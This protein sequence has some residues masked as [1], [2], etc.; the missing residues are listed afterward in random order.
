[1]RWSVVLAAPCLC[2]QDAL[3]PRQ[4]YQYAITRAA[5]PLPAARLARLGGSFAA[6]APPQAATSEKVR[7]R[8]SVPCGGGPRSLL[9]ITGS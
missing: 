4:D 7:A 6:S 9:R 1:M 8:G 3:P 2:T 5:P